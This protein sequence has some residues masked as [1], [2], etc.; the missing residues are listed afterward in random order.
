MSGSLGGTLA[1]PDLNNC[2]IDE[3][4]QLVGAEG[5]VGDPSTS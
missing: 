4:T 2:G 5:E 1:F 3:G